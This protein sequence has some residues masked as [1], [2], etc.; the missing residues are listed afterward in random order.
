M[1]AFMDINALRAFSVV[2]SE[3]NM[4]RAAG[5]LNISQPPLS[6]KIRNLEIQLGVELFVRRSSG[7]ELTQEGRKVLEIIRPLL[8]MQEDVQ[9][10]LD[11]CGKTEV[12]SV[13]F[14]TAFEQ[15]VYEPVIDRLKSLAK[16]APVIRRASSVQLANDVLRGNIQAAWV[17]LPL[18]KPGLSILHMPYAEPLLAVLPQTWT[19]SAVLDL[20]EMNGSP[21]FW[22]PPGRNPA[23]HERMQIVFRSLGFRPKY[24]DEPL[25]YEVLLAR[26]A[27]EEGWA[28]IPCSF[29][30]IQRKGI[31]FC[32]VRGL[33]PLELGIIYKTREGERLARECSH[34][35]ESR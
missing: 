30:T 17:A 33:P 15:S 4:R 7:L 22:F 10:Q 21:F 20:G 26:I 6:R 13:G 18:S 31:K 34:I 25:E 1:A 23:W 3:L 28:L 8:T 9:Q 5:L 11:E 32:P 29:A 27:A 16:N 24:I 2:A 14:T 19:V 12:C 35:L